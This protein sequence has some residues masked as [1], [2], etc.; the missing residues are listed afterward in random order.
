MDATAEERRAEVSTTTMATRCALAKWL[1]PGPAAAGAAGDPVPM[2]V[3]VMIAEQT[4]RVKEAALCRVWMDMPI[5]VP[6]AV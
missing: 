3:T 4:C 2:A 5:P 6:T 1:I